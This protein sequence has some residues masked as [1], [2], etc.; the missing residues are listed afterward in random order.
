MAKRDFLENKS[1]GIRLRTQA[2]NAEDQKVWVD[3]LLREEE[4][5]KER[6]Q[7]KIRVIGIGEGSACNKNVTS[8]L[9]L[10][11]VAIRS[12]F[13]L[14]K[15]PIDLQNDE[16]FCAFFVGMEVHEIRA[17]VRIVEYLH[18]RFETG[19][20][21]RL[22]NL[23]ENELDELAIE[24]DQ[25]LE[26]YPKGSKIKRRRGKFWAAIGAELQI[27]S[28]RDDFNTRGQYYKIARRVL[29]VFWAIQQT[30]RGRR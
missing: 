13:E 8:S 4:R 22:A 9:E 29:D 14:L 5:K 11:P 12:P 25:E 3:Y 6:E 26:K 30:G 10:R 18:M 7:K 15:N 27:A 16:R 20:G 21:A 17:V 1:L 2:N 23:N 19:L 28:I 24:A